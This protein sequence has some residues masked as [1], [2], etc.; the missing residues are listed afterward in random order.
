MMTP[1]V[2]EQYGT[3]LP[4]LLLVG[5]SHYLPNAST[6]HTDSE[7]WYASDAS[8]LNEIEKSWI[9]T[10]NIIKGSRKE[11]FKNKAHSI[12]R[13]S[14]S[15]LNENGP[16]FESFEEVAD[17]ISFYNFFQRPAYEGNSLQVTEED[18]QSAND[19]YAAVL[20]ELLPEKVI[21]LSNLAHSHLSDESRSLTDSIAVPHPGCVWWNRSAKKYGGRPGRELLADAAKTFKRTGL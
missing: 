14:F 21:F 12:W 15:V 4:K 2:G 5:E 7:V 3:I 1:F 6:Q 8:T 17:H 13:N 9:D 20:A 19:T 11:G 16:Q 18:Y 10:P